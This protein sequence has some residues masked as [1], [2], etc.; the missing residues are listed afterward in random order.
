MKYLVNFQIIIHV[1]QINLFFID[2]VG[3]DD[4]SFEKVRYNEL[5]AIQRACKG[6][7]D[8]S[9][10]ESNEEIFLSIELYGHNQITSNLF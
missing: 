7:Y 4:G 8:F 9:K 1:Y 5:R 2:L 3:I 6:K 10:T